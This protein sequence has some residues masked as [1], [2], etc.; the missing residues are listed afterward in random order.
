MTRGPKEP[1][2]LLKRCRE[3]NCTRLLA[4]R[5]QQ[6]EL[7]PSGIT[8]VQ[9]AAAPTVGGATDWLAAQ[10]DQTGWCTGAWGKMR[11][12]REAWEASGRGQD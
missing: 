11:A 1:G 2:A 6:T 7:D 3:C 12:K 4:L 10:C 5:G 8:K 9:Q